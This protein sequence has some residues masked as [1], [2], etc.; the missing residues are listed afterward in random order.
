MSALCQISVCVTLFPSHVDA[1]QPVRNAAQLH[2]VDQAAPWVSVIEVCIAPISRRQGKIFNNTSGLAH[3][4]FTCNN[5]W[6]SSVV[7]LFP[8]SGCAAEKPGLVG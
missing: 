5:G 3:V 7:Q 1:G 6:K 4:L 2:C 8:S